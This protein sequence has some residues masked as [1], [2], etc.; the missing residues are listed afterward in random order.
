[1]LWLWEG[2]CKWLIFRPCKA[3]AHGLILISD[4]PGAGH[5]FPRQPHMHGRV[6]YFCQGFLPCMMPSMDGWRDE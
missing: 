5:A 2:L 1:L 6:I 3:E 4:P